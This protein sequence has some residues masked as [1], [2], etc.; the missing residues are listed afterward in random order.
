[1]LHSSA[2]SLRRVGGS[3]GVVRSPSVRA[4]VRLRV[5][6]THTHTHARARVHAHAERTDV[7]A[8]EGE[9]TEMRHVYMVHAH[10]QASPAVGP[11]ACA[12]AGNCGGGDRGFTPV[13]G[14]EALINT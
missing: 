1:M 9:R 4:R 7:A 8:A 2:S 14:G 10:A 11:V 5:P 13:E 3:L 6:H 12:A